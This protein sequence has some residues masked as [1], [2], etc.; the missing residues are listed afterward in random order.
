MSPS[1]SSAPT[2]WL[3]DCYDGPKLVKKDSS[4]ITMCYYNPDM[5]QINDMNNTEVTLAINNV[6][7][8][9]VLPEQMRV[10]VH[11]DGVDS[12]NGGGDGFQCLDDDGN[13][14]DIEGKNEFS[15]ECYQESENDPFLA[16]IDIVITDANICATND[17][18]HPCYPDAEPILES[19]SWRIIVPCDFDEICTEAPTT[20]P[21][22]NPTSSQSGAPSSQPSD[23][24]S[25]NPSSG[26]TGSPTLNPTVTPTVGPTA[27]PSSVP[28]DGPS[29]NPSTGPTASP[30]S[31]P[32]S[33]PNAS[34]S[35]MPSDG[36]SLYPSSSP[37]KPPKPVPTNMPSDPLQA[38]TDS[39]TEGEVPNLP[40]FI[41]LGDDDDDTPWLPPLGPEECPED[42][43]LIEHEGV[44]DYPEGTVRILSQ[45]TTTVTVALT[46]AYTKTE[47]DYFYYQY[48]EDSFNN[49]CYEEDKVPGGNSIEITIECMRNSQIALLEFWV[50]DD[51]SKNV[52]TD[53]DNAVIPDCCY[54]TVPEDTPVTKYFLEIKCVTE[55]PEEY[56]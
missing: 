50:A 18:P 46:Q 26:P 49:K 14:I 17:V 8:S 48:K 32:S 54:P 40:P 4:D 6:W 1:T 12:I 16:V 38:S 31:S 23:G 29:L 24:P 44:T 43:L 15:V 9:S 36:P 56:E 41:T 22:Q 47:I 2:F 11:T 3:P 27:S 39:P 7:T 21:S 13:D 45:D 51:I 34:P 52:L 53:G 25:L 33:S 42:I 30:S 19:C 20:S 37:S 35:S 28:S 5:V 55:C 10:F